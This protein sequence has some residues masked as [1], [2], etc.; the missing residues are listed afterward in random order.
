MAAV[1][2][3]VPA[4]AAA[5]PDHA[6]RLGGIEPQGAGS[7]AVTGLHFNPAMLAAMR[8]SA[9]HASFGGGVLQQRVRRY[10]IDPETGDPTGDLTAPN[11][12]I[13]PELG[14]FVGGSLYL[15]PWAIGAGIY[16]LGSRY[17]TTS[18]N[19]L[20]YH[21]APRSGTPCASVGLSSCPPRGGAVSYRH[22][23]TL[24]FAYNGGAFQLGAAVHFPMV[25]ERF[26]F[27]NDTALGADEAAAECDDKEDPACAERVGFKGWTQWIPR[28]GQPAGF[29]AAVSIGAAVSLAG[30]TISIG[31]RYRTFPLR[32]SGEVQLGGVALVCRPDPRADSTSGVAACDQAEAGRASLRQRLPQQ[33]SVGAAMLLG[34]SRLWRLDLNAQWVDLCPGGARPGRCKTSGEQRLRLVGLDRDSFVLP[35]VLRYRG[36]TDLFSGDAFV[37]YRA[38]TNVDV[39]FAGHLSTPSVRRGAVNADLSQGWLLGGS[40]GA[41]L[42]VPK[43][44]LV[45]VPG[46]SLD[47]WLPRLVPPGVARFD[48]LAAAA[49]EAADG[50]INAAG[51]DAALEGRGRPTNAGRYFALSHTLSVALLFGD[52]GARLD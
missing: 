17:R 4:L 24:A 44:A 47:V 29:D 49:F 38:T 12:L 14:Y 39:L 10:E 3:M 18:A 13:N 26:T 52:T 48:P 8:G 43:T 27:D 46:Y 34:K 1:T 30:D 15:D 21:L 35:E 2:S 11:R 42:R 37:R 7:P 50:D 20:R 5:A 45:I 25:R 33:L 9:V 16:D 19:P 41:R 31:A 40:G 23:V 22:D 32:R 28:R 36:L 6:R 51:A